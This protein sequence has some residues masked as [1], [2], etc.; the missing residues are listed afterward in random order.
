MRSANH[1]QKATI[2]AYLSFFDRK[3]IK[4]VL[5]KLNPLYYFESTCESGGIG[6][7]AGLRIQ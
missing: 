7:R 1:K 5:D 6:R 4:K 2:H 3:N